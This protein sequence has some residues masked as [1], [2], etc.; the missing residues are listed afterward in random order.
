[1]KAT[2]WRQFLEEQRERYDK[3]LFTVTELANVAGSSS[4]A[5]NVELIR[6]RRQ[7]F[8]VRYARGLY[9]LPG[10]VSLPRLVTA[11]DAHAYIT[12]HYALYHH[13]LVTQRPATITCLTDRRSPRGQERRTAL[14]NVHL[15]CIHSRVYQPPEETGLATPAQAL[16]DYVYL[17]RR[18]GGLPE[19]LVTFRNLDRLRAVELLS[20][21]TRYPTS[22]RQHVARLLCR[23]A[24]PGSPWSAER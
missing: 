14:G 10:V 16:C 17:A 3:V 5:L 2:A 18:R 11:I 9:G 23:E 22:V 20:Q 13:Q 12:G 21:W 6:L 8:L 24:G 7:G 1:M 4:E 15:V 19:T